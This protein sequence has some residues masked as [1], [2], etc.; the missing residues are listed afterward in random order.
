M[1]RLECRKCG[2]RKNQPNYAHQ[3]PRPCKICGSSKFKLIAGKP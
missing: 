3:K 2:T 1:K